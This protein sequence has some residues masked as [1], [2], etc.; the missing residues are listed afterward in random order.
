MAARKGGAGLR[1]LIADD[2]QLV[3]AG[4]RMILEAERDLEVVGEA[5]DG[6]EAL[7]L[8]RRLRPDV[9]LM[10]IRMPRM[11]GLQAT[12]TLLAQPG[13]TSRV[14]ILTTFEVDEYVFEAMRSGAS[15]F[16]LKT[17]PP[18]ELVQAVRIVAA[19]D[20]L[21]APSVTRSVIAEFA[22]LSPQAREH[23]PEVET[24]TVRE[25]EVFKLVAAGLSNAEIAMRLYLGQ[26]TVKTHVG[27][28]LDKLG[29]RDRVHAV[30]YAYEH[31]IVSRRSK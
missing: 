25:L 4:L 8:A 1:I 13:V 2:Q 30:V 23:A 20:A 19:G 28:I 18:D 24:L 22:R 31:G 3:R 17:V 27:R 9:V 15:G 11:D 6:A 16:L 14:L 5:G 21:L 26:A 7:V 10:D 12:L 29:L